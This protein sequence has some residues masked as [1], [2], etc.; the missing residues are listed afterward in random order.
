MLTSFVLVPGSLA[1][2]PDSAGAPLRYPVTVRVAPSRTS[3]TCCHVFAA[4]DAMRSPATSVPPDVR[5]CQRSLFGAVSISGPR[6]NSLR[7]LTID[8]LSVI[9]AGRIHAETVRLPASR[10]AGA[11]RIRT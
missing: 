3:T 2:E 9:V 1:Y 11:S 7:L 6:M 5:C 4:V 8:C 10:S